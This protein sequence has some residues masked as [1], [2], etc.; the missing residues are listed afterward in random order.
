ME[1][2][3]KKVRVVRRRKSGIG[4]YEPEI[5]YLVLQFGSVLKELAC[6]ALDG[7]EL[8]VRLQLL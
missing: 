7:V 3:A 8:L 1:K 2:Q 6:F 4:R 5:L